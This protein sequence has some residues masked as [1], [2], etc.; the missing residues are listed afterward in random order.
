MAS[1]TGEGM[2]QVASFYNERNIFVTGGTGFIGKVLVH[3]LL[4]GNYVHRDSSEHLPRQKLKLTPKNQLW[5][6]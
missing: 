3:K 6:P 4:T 5:D 1:E 2:S